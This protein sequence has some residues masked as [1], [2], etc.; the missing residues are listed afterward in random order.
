MPVFTNAD[1]Q[2]CSACCQ[3]LK[4]VTPATWELETVRI[5]IGEPGEKVSE[6][7]SQPII[8]CGPAVPA[9]KKA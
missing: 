6:T 8:G 7:S 4:P 5:A 2:P 9:M 3:W 1:V